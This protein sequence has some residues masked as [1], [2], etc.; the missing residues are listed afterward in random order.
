MDKMHL[1]GDGNE[2][3]EPSVMWLKDKKGSE[4]PVPGVV[5]ESQ[6]AGGRGRADG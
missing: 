5:R 1:N 2:A 4:H 3:A 6:G